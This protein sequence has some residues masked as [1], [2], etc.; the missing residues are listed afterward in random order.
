MDHIKM[1]HDLTSIIDRLTEPVADGLA[2][3]LP[4]HLRPGEQLPDLELIQ[5]LMGRMVIARLEALIAAEEAYGDD[6]MELDDNVLEL[7]ERL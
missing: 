6:L 7:P 5:R 2:E 1:A 3:H 4:P